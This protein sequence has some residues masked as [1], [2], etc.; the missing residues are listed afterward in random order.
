MRTWISL[1]AIIQHI[2][3]TAVRLIKVKLRLTGPRGRTRDNWSRATS[4][5]LGLPAG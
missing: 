3:M 4:P 5:E 2:V 1:G